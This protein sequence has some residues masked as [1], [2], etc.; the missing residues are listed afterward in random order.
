MR[1]LTEQGIQLW[2]EDEWLRFRA[3]E[4]TISEE[5]TSSIATYSRKIRAHLRARAAALEKTC[6]LSHGQQAIWFLHQREPKSSVHNVSLVTR[7]RSKV[8]VEALKSAVQALVDRH[9]ILRTSYGDIDGV[10]CQKIAGLGV[11]IFDVKPISPQT[12][13]ELDAVVN[14]EHRRPFDLA[15]GSVF[16]VSLLTRNDTD[17]I[18][19]ITPHHIAIDGWSGVLLVDELFRLYAEASG[20]AP[21]DLSKPALDYSDYCAWQSAM[22][23]GPEGDRLWDYWKRAIAAPRTPLNLPTD[24]PRPPIKTFDGASVRFLL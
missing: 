10:V 15:R 24:R 2:F 21:A 14:A 13:E 6:E 5:Q 22:L 19:L 11:G 16:R 23:A 7:V 18:L 8:N 9:E 1:D 3:M 17:H 12:N 4:G 20:G